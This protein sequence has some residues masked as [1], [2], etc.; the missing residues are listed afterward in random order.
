MSKDNGKSSNLIG[1]IPVP[2]GN[3]QVNSGKILVALVR[4]GESTCLF[5]GNKL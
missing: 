5:Y 2:I 4:Y 3:L 1:K